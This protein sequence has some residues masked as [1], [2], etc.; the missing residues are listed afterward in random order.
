MDSSRIILRPFKLS[1]IDEFMVWAND[2]QVIRFTRMNGFTSKEDGLR[3][4][5][6][7]AIPHPWCRS[8]CLDDRS[9]GLIIIYPGFD[10]FICRGEL[11]Y[12]LASQYWGQG[13][14]TM[15]VK[16]ALSL[17]FVDFPKMERLQALVNWENKA[18]ERVL[19]KAGFLKEGL[20]RKYVVTKGK[21]L[22]IVSYSI[23]STDSVPDL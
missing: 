14:A 20:M 23:L 5:K 4:L 15:V 19:E 13:I 18:S 7:V 9:I 8:I 16:M 12:A 1:D 17:V 11:G 3:Y 10:E 6:E 22:D 21:T 2:D